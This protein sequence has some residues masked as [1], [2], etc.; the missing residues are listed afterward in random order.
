MSWRIS[1]FAVVVGLALLTQMGA[2]AQSDPLA[3]NSGT[4]GTAGAGPSCVPS[5]AG[6]DSEPPATFAT[7]R[8]IV[9]FKCSGS[10]CH[11][12]REPYLLDD[13]H[14]YTTLTTYRSQGCEN[15]LLVT[16]CDPQKSAIYRVQAVGGCG[17]SANVTCLCTH[18]S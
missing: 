10:G 2:C 11:N 6:S 13:E 9:R 8:E 17:T 18:A 5:D 4:G 3:Q 7:V 1:A 12:E 16:P 14:L 15:N